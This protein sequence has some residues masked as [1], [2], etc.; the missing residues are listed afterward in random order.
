MKKKLL[1]TLT[2][3][4]NYE[5]FET[6]SVIFVIGLIVWTYGCESKCKSIQDPAT[7]ITRHELKNEVEN[8]LNQV[9]TREKDLNRQDEIKKLVLEKT[10]LIAQTGTISPVGIISTLGLIVGFGATVDNVRKR[11]EIKK[12][13]NGIAS[14]ST[15]DN[16][17]DTG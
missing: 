14:D 9:E 6:W 13:T 2:I 7:M 4:F 16:F 3:L 5:K 12:L 15:N 17:T 1:E 8:F 10:M 11:R